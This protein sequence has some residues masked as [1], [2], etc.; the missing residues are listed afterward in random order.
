MR[1]RPRTILRRPRYVAD[2][3]RRCARGRGVSPAVCEGTSPAVGLAMNRQ[4]LLLGLLLGALASSCGPSQSSTSSTATGGGTSTGGTG[5]TG[6]GTSTGGTGGTG[7][8]AA[9]GGT[10]SSARFD[11][12]IAAIESER[13]EL[14]APG[15]AAAVIEDGKVTFAQ[16]FGSK[17]PN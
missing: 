8:G 10:S 14:G 17:D 15:V 1:A 6:G 3:R 13:K 12:L 16:G 5:G 11:A 9:A 7:G 2:G 4:S